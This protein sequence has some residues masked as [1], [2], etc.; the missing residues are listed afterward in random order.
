MEHA[1]DPVDAIFS[2]YGIRGPWESLHNT[3]IANRIYATRE[4]VLR[5]ATDH[6]DAFSDAR[7]ESVAAPV[8][9]AA[10]VLT[11]RILAFDD[12]RKLLDRPFSL[13]ERVNGETL[14]R[15]SS[16]ADSTPNTWHAVGRQL[17][18]LHT[19]VDQCDDPRGYLYQP[20][21]NPDL[22]ALLARLLSTGRV[23]NEL[24]REIGVFIEELRP[25]VSAATSVCFLHNDVHEMNIL[26]A[27]DD[28]LLALID[29]GDAG[30]GDPTLE[31]AQIP[32]SA[33]PYVMAGYRDV[34]SGL[35]GDD[36]KA[37]IVWDKL[38]YALEELVD[39]PSRVLPLDELRRFLNAEGSEAKKRHHVLA[40][41]PMQS[42]ARASRR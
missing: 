35:L 3:G 32:L 9:H 40:N 21:R 41:K 26:C 30:W 14:G 5:V 27:C 34:D 13:W 7:T 12:S 33:I 15:Y 28:S 31:F 24:A 19:R 2:A 25:A 8:A 29:W 20:D 37:K 6:P 11:P 16:I 39:D 4:V 10:G 17:A 23:G 1:P 38:D 22:G 36:P 42:N 18:V